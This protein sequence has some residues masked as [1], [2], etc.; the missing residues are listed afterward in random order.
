MFGH[1]S[2]IHLLISANFPT[3]VDEDD[4]DCT[5]V[6]V[7]CLLTSR[8]RRISRCVFLLSY[9]RMTETLLLF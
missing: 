6:D 1:N 2:R 3:N 7:K 5:H 9:L 8:A 4:L